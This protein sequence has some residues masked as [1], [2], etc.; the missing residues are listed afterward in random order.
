MI[1]TSNEE[2][3]NSNNNQIEEDIDDDFNNV[4][5]SQYDKTNNYDFDNDL[6]DCL[7]Y[8][9]TGSKRDDETSGISILKDLEDKWENIE[10][11]KKKINRPRKPKKENKRDLLLPLRKAII[12]E[13]KTKF[14]RKYQF[15]KNNYNSNKDFFNFASNLILEMEKLKANN[16]FV[17]EQ[18]IKEKDI[19]STNRNKDQFPHDYSTQNELKNRKVKSF[20]IQEPS[21][22]DKPPQKQRVNLFQNKELNS[23][24][25]LVYETPS[26][27]DTLSNKEKYAISNSLANKMKSVFN[28]ITQPIETANDYN[29]YTKSEIVIN[30]EGGEAK[31][32]G[33]L[34]SLEKD[35]DEIF[36][37]IS[38]GISIKYKQKKY[39][40]K[41]EP[42]PERKV[43][44]E[45]DEYFENLKE[46]VGF[47][48]ARTASYNS[49]DMVKGLRDKKITKKLEENVR[50][51]NNVLD[52][53]RKI[54]K[55]RKSQKNIMN[56]SFSKN[57]SFLS[58]N[59]VHSMFPEN[60]VY[61]KNKFDDTISK[62]YQANAM[63][64]QK[65]INNK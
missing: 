55:S 23:I 1:T 22:R 8:T 48:K 30:D 14:M 7:Q 46:E 3:N 42:K 43:E 17:K 61:S 64:I 18:M 16:D 21:S 40:N 32:I 19:P 54:K 6:T 36:T 59:S 49:G 47:K 2:E 34:K 12:D 29:N 57:R 25:N 38:P 13:V 62:I 24:E 51:L 65:I 63:K 50:L 20:L 56:G 52:D 33:T 31:H 28:D 41:D 37:Q 45:E 11:Q 35:F 44:N 39:I 5:I 27:V 26:Q 10:K 58:T 9:V 4:H 53:E 15:N 60:R